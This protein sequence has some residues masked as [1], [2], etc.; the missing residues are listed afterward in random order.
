MATAIGAH[1]SP[2]EFQWRMEDLAS[3][4]A[5]EKIYAMKQAWRQIIS[6]PN[7]P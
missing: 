1:L 3:Q 5:L 7:T 4:A 6:M 2:E